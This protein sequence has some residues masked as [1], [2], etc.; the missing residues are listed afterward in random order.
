MAVTLTPIGTG[1]TNWGNAVDG[2]WTAI[3]KAF[4]GD[5][6]SPN[7]YG[8]G[9]V[10]PLNV[11]TGL[12]VGSYAGVNSAP[13]NGLIVS[14]NVGI[15]VT[16]PSTLL[17]VNPST[18]NSSIRAGGI[19]IQSY[20]TN[21]AWIANNNYYNGGNQI[22]RA[23]GY[24]M[25]LGFNSSGGIYLSTAPSGTGGNTATMTDRFHILNSGNIGIGTTAPGTPLDVIG[26][27]KSR[28]QT[29]GNDGGINIGVTASERPVVEFHVSDNS[30][31][32]KIEIN[33]IN[34]GTGDRLGLFAYNGFGTLTEVLSVRGFG[35]VG[36]GTTSPT[37]Y[38]DIPASATSAATLRIRT[39]TAPTSPNDGDMWQD[40]TNLKIRINGITKT[41]V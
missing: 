24:A 1:N 6:S 11:S 2:Y 7:S 21:N 30:I 15:G 34:G 36:I 41:I 22:Y 8:N 40:G 5:T 23:N 18:S 13:S 28:L 4:S 19:E 27:I 39:G 10:G 20:A 25:T 29:A 38:L 26:T 9:V 12:S 17:E 3:T 35:Y 14:G 32:G 37:A 16:S 33:D 31:R